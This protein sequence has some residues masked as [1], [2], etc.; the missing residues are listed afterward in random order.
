MRFI[1][2]IHSFKAHLLN[3]YCKPGTVLGAGD[4]TVN[5]TDK[6]LSSYSWHSRTCMKT[7]GNEKYSSFLLGSLRRGDGG[8]SCWQ[9]SCHQEERHRAWDLIQRACTLPHWLVQFSVPRKIKI[10][11]CFW[12]WFWFF[13]NQGE[14]GQGEGG[15]ASKSLPTNQ[16]LEFPQK[17]I[18]GEFGNASWKQV[19]FPERPILEYSSHPRTILLLLFFLSFFILRARIRWAWSLTQ[20]SIPWPWD[21][22]LRSNQELDVQMTEPTVSLD[23]SYKSWKVCWCSYIFFFLNFGLGSIYCYVFT[24]INFLFYSV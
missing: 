21:Q 2:L 22:D 5:K 20:G 10:K 18:W 3:T 13:L 19:I 1:P 23:I 16:Y 24:F 8:R 11:G 14:Q 6:S 15:P 12:F 9:P 4:R 17:S 7:A